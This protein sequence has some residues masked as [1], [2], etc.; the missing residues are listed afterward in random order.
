MKKWMRIVCTIGSVLCMTG[1]GSSFEPS[2]TSLYVCKD[3]KITQAIVESFEKDHYSLSELESM[4]K[5]EISTY[6]NR[7][8]EE[9]IVLNRLEEKDQTLYLLLDYEDAEV[10]RSH[11]E[12]YCFVGTIDE[13][14][15]EGHS[16]YMDFKD[17][18]YEE[19]SAAVVTENKKNHV[20][21]L[22]EEGVVQLE[23]PVKY[24]SN[25]VEIISDHMVQVMPIEDSA[26]YAYIIF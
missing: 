25:N 18:D 21:I 11:S 16:F 1:C 20:V 3:G 7:Y 10:Y 8:G 22:K 12:E 5:K 19:L 2:I 4:V 23:K 26:E 14:L 13:A 9:K 6:N 15:D 17:V 24:V